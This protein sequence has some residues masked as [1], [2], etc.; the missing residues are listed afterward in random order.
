[1]PHITMF[2]QDGYPTTWDWKLYL[3]KQMLSRGTEQNVVLEPISYGPL[4][5]YA[6]LN[7][8]LRKKVSAPRVVEAEETEVVVS[9][10]KRSEFD[11][12][13][14]YEGRNANWQTTTDLIELTLLSSLSVVVSTFLV[15]RARFL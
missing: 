8:I 7:G 14:Q 5:L 10:T 4:V 13:E 1:M 15:S 6:R 12:V 11:F 9:V 2:R 3:G